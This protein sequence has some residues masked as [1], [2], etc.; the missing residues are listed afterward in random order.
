MGIIHFVLRLG[1][2]G[3]AALRRKI[4]VVGDDYCGK[5]CLLFTLCNE[6]LPSPMTQL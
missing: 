2:K 3:M 5:T 6:Q 4:T 1:F